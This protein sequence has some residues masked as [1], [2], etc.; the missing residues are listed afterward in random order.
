[1]S[2]SDVV[3]CGAGIGGLAAAVALR[4]KGIKTTVLEQAPE[5]GEVGTGL[6]LGPNATRVL[7][8]LGLQ[9]KM[10]QLSLI[11]QESVQRRWDGV[12]LAK[13]VLGSYATE[14]YGTPY[15]QVH[16][17]DLHTALYEAAIDPAGPGTPVTVVTG[18]LVTG[19]DES[20]PD[21][22]AALTDN[23]ERYEASVLVG[24][25]GVRSIVR[26]HIGGPTEI[27]DSG[28]MAFRTLIDGKAVAEDPATRFLVDWQAANFWLGENRHLVVYP[29]RNMSAI[30][31]V[32]VIPV[33][34]E[35]SRE[36]RR[37]SNDEELLSAYEGFESRVAALLSKP[38]TDLSLWALKHQEPFSQWSRGHITLLGDAAHA[39]VPYVSQGASQAIED[40]YVLAD[41]IAGAAGPDEIPAVL[42]S[43]VARRAERARF[44][45]EAALAK[46]GVFHLPDGEE[47]R[48]RDAEMRAESK[49]VGAGLD[50]IYS[51]T[52][53]NDDVTTENLHPTP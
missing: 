41:E 11:V 25:D 43:Y 31:I 47:Q 8:Q 40:G 15:L 2:A 30:N 45:Q 23:G 24:A 18:A 22:P 48:Q 13:T 39:M 53:L 10:E 14:R 12:I 20:T 38:K 1:M 52:P 26:E 21:R 46:Q 28:D 50:Y 7:Y 32:G 16:R 37:P 42:S 29:I 9:E 33:S 34:E 51:G 4:A 27:L 49:P 3:I 5:L 44:V 36:G 35:V 19:V 17:A 6:Q